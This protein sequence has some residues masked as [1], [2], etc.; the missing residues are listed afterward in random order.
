MDSFRSITPGNFWM[1]RSVE[2]PLYIDVQ[3]K[4]L[5][6]PDH[7]KKYTMHSYKAISQKFS[8]EGEG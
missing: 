2:S 1:V 3:Q 7:I 5:S 8:R 4:L 6:L